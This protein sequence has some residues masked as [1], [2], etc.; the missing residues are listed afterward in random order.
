MTTS[1][2]EKQNALESRHVDETKNLNT[3]FL[4]P[5]PVSLTMR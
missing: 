4:F 2:G 5:K 1:R 3:R